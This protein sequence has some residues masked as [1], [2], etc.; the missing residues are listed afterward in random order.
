M[1]V[2]ILV[3]LLAALAA[4]VVAQPPPSDIAGHWAE[5]AIAGLLT[6]GIAETYADRTFRPDEPI[7]RGDFI[8]WM[9][10]AVGLPRTSVRVA[11][12]VDVPITH[13]L[14]PFVEAAVRYRLIGRAATF[15][16]GFA[17]RRSDAMTTA[18]IAL[19][20]G[21][22][23]GSLRSRV[24]PYEDVGVLDPTTRGAVAVAIFLEPPLLREPPSPMLRPL[25]AMTRAE[26][27]S[28][29]WSFLQAVEN[30]AA[31]RDTATIAPGLELTMEKRGVLRILPVIRIQIGAFAQE[32]NAQRLAATMRGRGLTAVVEFEDGLYKVRVGTFTSPTDAEVLKD[33]LAQEGFPAW[34][35]TT[36]PNLDIL[37]APFWTAAVVVDLQAA[38][39]Q[40]A[41]GDGI[42]MV[43]Q[44]TSDVARRT[45][46]VVAV[47]GDFYGTGGDP[48]GCLLVGGTVLSEPHPERTCLGITEERTLVLDRVRLTGAV[49][50]GDARIA[51]TGINRSRGAEELILYRP[52]FDAGT[53]TNAFGAEATV[54]NGVVTSVTDGQ[55]NAPIPRDGVVLSGHGRARQWI[56]QRLT[57]GTPVTIEARLVSVS[58]DLKWD[59]VVHAVGGGPRLV[60]AGRLVAPE[61]F[62]RTLTDRRHPRTALGL[63]PDGRV[64][65]LVVDGRNP[66][67]SLGMTLMELALEL[68]R[69]GAIDG[70][71]LDGG[72]ST[73]MVI[74]GRVI[75]LPSDENG[76]RP[77]GSILLVL[78]P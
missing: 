28:L 46:A 21:F 15:L 3:A 57:A 56:L 77:V 54:V 58:G 75:N 78:P 66:Y 44:K 4:P 7:S 11:T 36:V 52:E 63:L 19:G 50:A 6:R 9:V 10:I 29:I 14:S 69:H 35:L 8:R 47:N 55:G 60:A 30:G 67:H 64:L 74:N 62:P 61:G 17:V 5:R 48:L 13:P 12:F 68:R 27:A 20:Y 26:A 40:P 24:L 71:N 23:S 22:E 49:L 32:D 2:A 25:E 16:P 65:L 59:R 76:E 31:L 73:T 41:I 53:R 45:G 42:R 39:L 1:R 72:G 43:R 33:Q 18:V 70:L 51:L 37:P 34:L 38:R